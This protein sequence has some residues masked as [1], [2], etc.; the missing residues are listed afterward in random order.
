MKTC[1]FIGVNYHGSQRIYGY[2]VH[3]D[4]KEISDLGNDLHPDH[5]AHA[6]ERL[7][8]RYKKPI[9]VTESGI[10]DATDR[11]RKWWLMQS[12]IAMQQALSSGVELI[13][14]LHGGYL[15]HLNGIRAFGPAMVF[16][17]W[18]GKV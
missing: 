5:L 3:N 4:N 10:A 9:L 7:S 14:Y 13:G 2:R 16:M 15:I 11:R 12:I 8:E 1:D 18:I 6:L 17:K